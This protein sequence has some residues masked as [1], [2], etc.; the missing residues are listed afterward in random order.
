MPE[1]DDQT[2]NGRPS[3][4]AAPLAIEHLAKEINLLREELRSRDEKIL[5]L[6]MRIEGDYKLLLNEHHNLARRVRELEL[7]M[8]EDPLVK[9]AR[10]RAKKARGK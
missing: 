8:E 10:R 2:P 6:L 9:K 1:P 5:S 7:R 3:I 4:P